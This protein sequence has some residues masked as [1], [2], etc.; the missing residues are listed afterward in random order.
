[1]FEAP[2]L[3]GNVV[4]LTTELGVLQLEAI[5]LEEGVLFYVAMLIAAFA[6]GVLG[7]SLGAL[8][9]FVFMGFVI[10]GG[11]AVRI[12]S[13]NSEAIDVPFYTFD[14]AFGAFFGPHITFAAGAAASAYAAK[15]GYMGD[16]FGGG[17]GYH[18]GK[19]ILIAFAGKHT[20]VLL[21]GGAFG[22]L[23]YLIWLVSD[24]VLGLPWDG[25][26]MG[27]VLS[28]LA[29][30]L[31]FGYDVVGDVDADGLLDLSPFD[32][33]AT[34]ETAGEAG[35]PAE[36]LDVEPWLPWF[37]DWTN[38][39]I[40]GFAFGALGGLTF[41]YTGSMFLAFGISAATLIFLNTGITEDFA[42]FQ[43][44]VPVTH[45]IT[46]P[47]A[48]APAAYAGLGVAPT[49]G[50]VHGELLL[51]EAV[52]LGAVF[53]IIGGLLGEL[54]ERVFYAHADTHWDPPATSIVL[55]SF[56]IAVLYLIGVFGSPG[57]VPV[58]V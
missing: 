39:A 1:M 15:K 23:G 5:G 18:D 25:I 37:R 51:F 42:I 21:V 20:D 29:H 10:I 6:G 24:P 40:V 19:N 55:T 16:G 44:P 31:A 14:I 48:T 45:H 49:I 4:Q 30:R 52:V 34:H 3:T 8:P 50:A 54:A 57:Y 2:A 11:E 33:E 47:A 17:W 7:A 56:L 32:R 58:P 53:G 9:A 13:M 36:R 28:A 41:Y 22:V 27:V 35:E 26:A 46:L 43:V 12:A 38:V